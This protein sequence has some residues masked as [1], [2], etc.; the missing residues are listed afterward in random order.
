[1]WFLVGGINL[2]GYGTYGV[3][4]TVAR[5]GSLGMSL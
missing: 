3:G 5:V 4:I 2:E 1:M